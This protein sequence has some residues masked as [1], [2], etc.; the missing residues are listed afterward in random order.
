MKD[1]FTKYLSELKY[2]L[3]LDGE[4]STE[5]K[6]E[7]KNHSLVILWDDLSAEAAV[8]TGYS[9][10]KDHLYVVT[11]E[12]VEEIGYELME[13]LVQSLPPNVSV[14]LYEDDSLEHTMKDI[15][16]FLNRARTAP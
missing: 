9:T 12:Q 4:N 13:E 11:P 6:N 15:W 3:I 5:Y 7:R 2:D 14:T 1:F 8:K 10:G 16:F